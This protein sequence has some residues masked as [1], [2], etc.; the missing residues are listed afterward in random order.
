MQRGRRM[1]FD[2]G[3]VRIGVAISDQEAILAAPLTTL[4][5][6]S[7]TLQR[8]LSELFFD[9]TPVHVYIGLPTHLSGQ[10]SESSLKATRFGEMIRDN[11]GFPV[12]MLDERFSTK[13]AENQLRASG[14]S[15]SRNRDV[16]DQLAAA[17]ILEFALMIEKNQ[18][19]PA[20]IL[21]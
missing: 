19:K 10:A 12:Y 14:K 2:Y 13:N 20:G 15:A 4:Q 6:N 1:A 8:E 5:S 17:N 11:F 16:I 21:L 7:P 18:F 9:I 3:D